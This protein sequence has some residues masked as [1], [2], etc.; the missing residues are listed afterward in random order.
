M[1]TRQQYPKVKKVEVTKTGDISR[2]S[3]YYDNGTM[4]QAFGLGSIICNIDPEH[5]KEARISMTVVPKGGAAYADF[6]ELSWVTAATYQG[7]Q[8]R[9][10][11]SVCSY[12]S[13]DQE[14]QVDAKTRLT[15]YNTLLH[16]TNQEPLPPPVSPIPYQNWAKFGVAVIYDAI[17]FE[18]GSDKKHITARVEYSYEAFNAGYEA[19]NVIASVN[20][21]F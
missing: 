13:G 9:E 6:P 1:P 14:A 16:D 4:Q 21:Q 8:D 5:P 10:G 12:I 17:Y 18:N 15:E 3:M 11:H 2:Y 19:H 7:E 20:I